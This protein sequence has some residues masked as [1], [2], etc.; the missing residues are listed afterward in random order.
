MNVSTFN[1]L[2]QNGIDVSTWMYCPW[3]MRWAVNELYYEL[4][5]KNSSYVGS[6]IVILN[7]RQ[8]G[9]KHK[10]VL[11]EVKYYMTKAWK[12]KGLY[13]DISL[14]QHF[15]EYSKLQRSWILNNQFVPQWYYLAKRYKITDIVPVFRPNSVL[16]LIYPKELFTVLGRINKMNFCKMISLGSNSSEYN[17]M[18]GN[19]LLSYNGTFF[20]DGEFEVISKI[21][22]TVEPRICL[23]DSAFIE[24]LLDLSSMLEPSS[25]LLSLLHVTMFLL[26]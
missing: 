10:S 25:A 3:P 4:D 6:F 19:T 17:I 14:S 15:L 24:H 12:I 2:L 21:D 26:W 11:H 16:P 9:K 18:A 23:E 1:T 8:R 13:K 22:G 20:F 5:N 7:S